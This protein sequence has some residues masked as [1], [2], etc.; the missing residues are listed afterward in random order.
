[1]SDDLDFIQNMLKNESYVALML[2]HAAPLVRY[3][4]QRVRE[5][6]PPGGKSSRLQ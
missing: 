2:T 3:V 5:C 1:L 6:T 4:G